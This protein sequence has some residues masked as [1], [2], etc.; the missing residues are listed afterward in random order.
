M[1]IQKWWQKRFELNASLHTMFLHTLAGHNLAANL[2]A[3]QVQRYTGVPAC[4]VVQMAREV[5]MVQNGV[6]MS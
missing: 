4:I 1:G 3:Q 6:G 5:I 2:E